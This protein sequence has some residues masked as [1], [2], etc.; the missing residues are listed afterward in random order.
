MLS[1][2]Q[3]ELSRRRLKPDAVPSVFNISSHL[4]HEPPK[5]RPTRCSHAEQRRDVSLKRK[6]EA[7]DEALAES[8]RLDSLPNLDALVEKLK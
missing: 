4:L 7:E 5:E 8:M 1:R 6:K 3:G 2:R